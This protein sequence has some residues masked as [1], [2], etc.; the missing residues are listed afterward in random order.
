MGYKNQGWQR[1]LC[2]GRGREDDSTAEYTVTI[3]DIL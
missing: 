2:K 1:L 3:N